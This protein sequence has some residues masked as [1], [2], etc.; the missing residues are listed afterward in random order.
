MQRASITTDFL[1]V[2]GGVIGTNIARGLKKRYP[3][4]QVTLIEKESSCGI[5]ASFRNSR[6]LHAGFYLFTGQPKS[7]IHSGGQR[8]VDSLC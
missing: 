6:I 4:S 3:A 8:P 7:E 1:V 5:H 2:G